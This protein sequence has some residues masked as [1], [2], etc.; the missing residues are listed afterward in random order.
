MKIRM[1]LSAFMIT[2][3]YSGSSINAGHVCRTSARSF[4]TRPQLEL[5]KRE[6]LWDRMAL[7]AFH[8][9]KGIALGIGLGRRALDNLF[10]NGNCSWHSMVSSLV[11]HYIT[12]HGLEPLSRQ[13]SGAWTSK[14]ELPA[15]GVVSWGQRSPAAKIEQTE[16][17]A[18]PWDAYLN[19]CNQTSTQK[20][21]A[22]SVF[23]ARI[24]G[25]Y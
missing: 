22:S 10:F 14:L 12:F 15:L 8:Y 11:V 4:L 6:T 20:C 2:G 16:L 18:W 21:L 17:N 5:Y 9:K 19:K 23:P 3:S 7:W 1:Q 24:G 13:K 25:N